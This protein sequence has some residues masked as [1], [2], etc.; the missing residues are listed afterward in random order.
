MKCKGCG[1]LFYP[2]I[3]T[4]YCPMCKLT[5]VVKA[6]MKLMDFEKAIMVKLHQAGIKF[7]KLHD[8]LIIETNDIVKANKIIAEVSK[9]FGIQQGKPKQDMT[10]EEHE[11]DLRRAYGFKEDKKDDGDGSTQ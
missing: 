1:C 9:E 4:D 11:A 10:V 5:E 8:E 3:P 2:Q 6:E 7:H